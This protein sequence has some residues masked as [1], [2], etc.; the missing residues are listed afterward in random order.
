[1]YTKSP[2]G[3]LGS[4]SAETEMSLEAASLQIPNP[5]ARLVIL[6]LKVKH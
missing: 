2:Q 3:E 4:C 1:M 6:I 5:S